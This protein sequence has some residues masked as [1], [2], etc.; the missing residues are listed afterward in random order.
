VAKKEEKA[1]EKQEEMA[2]P[3]VGTQEVVFDNFFGADVKEV[4]K[5]T[6]T[7]PIEKVSQCLFGPKTSVYGFE[8][9]LPGVGMRLIRSDPWEINSRTGAGTRKFLYSI[10]HVDNVFQNTEIIESVQSFSIRK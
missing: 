5:S 7:Y 6:L 3:A 10:K 8:Q 2:N 9:I 4:F 1:S